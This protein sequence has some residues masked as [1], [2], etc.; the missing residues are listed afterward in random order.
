MLPILA[1]EAAA[2]QQ[3]EPYEKSD[4]MVVPRRP[5]RR[6]DATNSAGGE[7]FAPVEELAGTKSCTFHAGPGGC[8]KGAQCT[9]SHDGPSGAGS[10]DDKPVGGDNADPEAPP[11]PQLCTY[12]AGP[13]G[14]RKGSRCGFSHAG[15]SGAPEGIDRDLDERPPRDE[16]PRSRRPPPPLAHIFTSPPPPPPKPSMF[17]RPLVGGAASSSGVWVPPIHKSPFDRASASTSARPSAPL[18]PPQPAY[19][20]YDPYRTAP[21]PQPTVALVSGSSTWCASL[22]HHRLRLLFQSLFLNCVTVRRRKNRSQIGTMTDRQK[23]THTLCIGDG[24][25]GSI[26]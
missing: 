7:G 24:I 13:R 5:P 18:P 2:R 21:V 6:P 15:P 17:V 14:C 8:K 1:A 3:S 19:G 16:M 20:A 4:V 10:S 23:H 12:Y 9:Y 26:D 25:V 11:A 22:R